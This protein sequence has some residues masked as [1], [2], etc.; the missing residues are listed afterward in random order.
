MRDEGNHDRAG[1]RR[2]RCRRRHGLTRAQRLAGGERRH[3]PARARGD[4][5]ARLP[6]QP[7]GARA[8]DRAHERDRRRRAVLHPAVRGRAPARRRRARWRGGLPADPASTSSGP[9]QRRERLPLARARGAG[10]TACSRLA[11]AGRRARLRRL[12][13]RRR[14]DRAAR[15]RATR[16]LPCITID[17]VEGGRMAAEHLLELGHRRIAFVGDE[18]ENLFGFDSSA[19][20]RQGFEAALAGRGRAARPGAAILRGRTAATAARAAAAELLARPEPPDAPSSPPPTSRRSACSR[21]R[22]PP[23]VPVPE[24]LSVIGF[25]DVEA[26]ELHRADHGRAAARGERRAGRRAAAARVV[27]RARTGPPTAARDRRPRAPRAARR[28]AV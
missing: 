2:G 18:E 7:G 1:R 11:R 12:R 20:R 15:P 3:A 28:L 21:R 19:R 6:A 16:K 23:G 10:S 8:L 22:R 14:A 4:R 5:G 24:Q 25:D 27:R 13:A 17:D 26:A 9:D